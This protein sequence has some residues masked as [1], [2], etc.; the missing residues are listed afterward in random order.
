MKLWDRKTVGIGAGLL[1]I[2]GILVV[3]TLR[4]E[5]AGEYVLKLLEG[6]DLRW[7]ALAVL[8]ILIYITC[9][10]VNIAR[11]L[12]LA[13]CKTTIREGI[14][15][16]FAGFFFSSITPS[17]SGGQP[18]QLYFMNRDKVQLSKGTFA[19]LTEL[20]SFE[21]ALIT[22]GVIGLAMTMRESGGLFASRFGIIFAAGFAVNVAGV[23][24][25]IAIVFSKK[26]SRLIAHLITKVSRPLR[27][28]RSKVLRGIAEYRVAA[29]K[30]RRNK[31]FVLALIATSLV[32]MTAYQS[33]PF[34]C[35][36]ALGVV[37]L[38]WLMVASMQGLLFVSISSLPLPG[39]AGVMEGGYALMFGA[40]FSSNL[41]GSMIILARFVNFILPLIISGL[42]L[43]T[44]RIRE[45][46][47]AQIA[48]VTN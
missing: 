44:I 31:R 29:N 8:M 32:Q 2:I 24:L 12:K 7:L 46:H 3:Q 38:S 16:A 37:N 47:I 11:T 20:M 21:I 41:A 30:L 35:L 40:M 15:Y 28:P 33:I 17:A 48:C 25:L 19:L 6:V 23:S 42:A 27:V 22:W 14:K 39:G 45:C 4:K 5:L 18:A 9:E 34:F 26:L 43:A 10:G 13:G 36:K 1:A